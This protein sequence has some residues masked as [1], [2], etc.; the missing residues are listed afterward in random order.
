MLAL[1]ESRGGG[2]LGGCGWAGLRR[3]L[4]LSSPFPPRCQ[5][6]PG[7]DL[8]RLR[9]PRSPLSFSRSLGLS[10]S[11][12]LSLAALL[13]ALARYS[14]SFSPSSSRPRLSPSP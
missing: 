11:L 6:R 14:T 8:L 2:L 9:R 1:F 4:L 5:S 3:G 12:F 7:P 13:G 10:C